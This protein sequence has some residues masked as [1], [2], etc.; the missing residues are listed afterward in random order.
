MTTFTIYNILE[1]IDGHWLIKGITDKFTGISTDSR[2][3][4]PGDLFIAI[5]GDNFDG[6][7]YL[8]KAKSAGAAGAVVCASI[9]GVNHRTNEP[10]QG[11]WNLIEVIDT[12][13]AY[14]RIARFHRRKY[15]IP[16]IGITGSAGKTTTKEFTAA[17][18]NMKYKTLKTEANFNNEIGL[19]LTLL[20]LSDEYQAAVVEMGMRGR[21]QIGYLTAISRPT[22][23]VITNV[24]MTHMELLGSQDAI[25]HAKA[26][27]LDEMSK[28]S[29]AILPF[30][31]KY[32]SMLCEHAKGE[33]FTFG[34]HPHSDIKAE[35]IE[36]MPGGC[37]SFNLKVN[38]ASCRVNLSVP[39]RHQVQNA[40][41]AAAV[42]F[43]SG[44]SLE[45]I[46]IGLA[47]YNGEKGRMQVFTSDDGYT[48]VD[49]TYNANPAA[50]Q[51]T[52]EFL[53]E[54]PGNKKIAVI[55]DMRELGEMEKELHRE[56]GELAAALKIDAVIATGEL[57]KEYI[58]GAG[59]IA[60]WQPDHDAVIA[61]IKR[62]VSPGD[63][64]LVKGS[65]AMQMDIVVTGLK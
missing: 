21:G 10:K 34:L 52:L 33:I 55:S 54:C 26:E 31:D 50:M 25:A 60:C 18:L 63:I 51:A 11:D 57:G 61:E 40:L 24:G 15:K 65:R 9:D 1:A 6:H 39:G 12:V 45:E 58:V 36:I 7:K 53:A 37:V 32:F 59:D 4:K 13:Y 8:D 23:G 28:S 38:F 19:P 14:G 20:K 62:I 16:I 42:G 29:L 30:D 48:V 3:V 5:K 17:V 46:A 49:D 47:N 44:I 56:I 41:A 2:N 43:N 35:K 22:I 27:L 64:V